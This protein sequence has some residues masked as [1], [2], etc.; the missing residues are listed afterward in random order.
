MENKKFEEINL[1]KELLQGVEKMGFTEMTPIQRDTIP[2]ILEGRDIIGQAQTGTGKTAAFGIPVLEMVDPNNKNV[3][4]LILCPTREL[5]IQVAKEI[6]DLG[7]F[8]KNVFVTAIYGG[9]SISRQ[10]RDLKKGVQIVVGT[11]GRVIDHINRKTLKLNDIKTMIL[12]EADEMFDMGFRDDISLVMG[13]LEGKI[14]TVFFSATMPKSIIAFA[15][16]YQEDPIVIKATKLELTMPRI[17]QYYIELNERV[18]NEALCR[19]IDINSP[20]LSVVFTNTKRR[21]DELVADLQRRGYQADALH[22]D[23]S[24]NQRDAVMNKFRKNSIDILVATDVAARGIDVDE[25]DMVFNY[26]IP[27]D[28]EYYVHRIGRTGRAGREG[29]AY[30]FVTNKDRRQI[31]TI[32][33]YANTKIEKTMIPTIEDVSEVREEGIKEEISGVI[34]KNK[35]DK[36]RGL[37]EGLQADGYSL[38]DIALGSISIYLKSLSQGVNEDLEKNILSENDYN[39]DGR[40]NRRD[41]NDKNDRSSRDGRDGRDNRRERKDKNSSNL[42]K[43]SAS[44]IYINAG[45]TKGIG[46]ANVLAAIIQETGIDKDQVGSIDIFDKFTFVDIDKKVDDRVIEALDNKK[47]NNKVV[48]VEKANRRG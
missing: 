19:L 30:S 8:K 41:R 1:S 38:E 40:R 16:K 48:S 7:K 42:D 46:P 26:D 25:V 5:S 37:F 22:G 3:Q 11:P 43:S 12:D 28:E 45:R 6:Q 29:S 31:K 18:K 13:K 24:Q 36:A 35:M 4:A 33:R 21:A 15:S 44:R 47:I 2:V 14:Q 32:E 10:I 27:R 34:T 20:R 23:L 39:S 17:K 9:E